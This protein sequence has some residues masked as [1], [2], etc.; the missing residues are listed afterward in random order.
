MFGI[1]GMLEKERFLTPKC[2]DN[3]QRVDYVCVL[4]MH[5]LRSREILCESKE[6]L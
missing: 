5:E 2:I 1:K 3:K 4:C 6:T